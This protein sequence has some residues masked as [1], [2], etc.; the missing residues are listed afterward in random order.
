MI[1]LIRLTTCAFLTASASMHAQQIFPVSE[2]SRL[3]LTAWQSKAFA[4][5]TQYTMVTIDDRVA[6]AA[7]SINSAS[8]LWREVEVDLTTTPYL[9]WS[10]QVTKPLRGLPERTRVGDDYVARI[11]AI[12]SGGLFFWRTKSVCYVWSGTEP[13]GEA[14]ENAY[15]ANVVMLAVEDEHSALAQW[16]KG[17]RNVRED[18]K[19]YHN[20]DITHLDA[21]AIMTDT[22]NSEGLARA[23]YGDIYFSAE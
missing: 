22:D 19:K 8:G 14:W 9:S 13:K 7:H 3:G 17:K 21:V 11:Y 2:F 6:V 20:M 16:H 1:W 23:Y 10:W 4:G 12:K 5:E 18:F 15:T